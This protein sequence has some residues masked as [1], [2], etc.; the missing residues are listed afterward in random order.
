MAS[1]TVLPSVEC[2]CESEERAQ[3]NRHEQGAEDRYHGSQR[4]TPLR[5]HHVDL[6]C[7]RENGRGHC[8]SLGYDAD[9]CHHVMRLFG[10]F[11]T[12]PQTFRQV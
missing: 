7:R 9:I 11:S 3:A 12:K 8:H 1:Q 6:P 5:L 4:Q 10:L 2:R